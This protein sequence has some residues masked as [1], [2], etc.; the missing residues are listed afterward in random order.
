MGACIEKFSEVKS[1]PDKVYCD[2]NFI[3]GLQGY[4]YDR[5]NPKF[6][7]NYQFWDVLQKKSVSLFT[8]TLGVN[9]A[10]YI[11]FYLNGIYK[12]IKKH[13]G[14]ASEKR[15]PEKQ[16]RDFRKSNVK[17]YEQFYKSNLFRVKSLLQ[18]LYNC[19]FIILP[20]PP[21]S[22]TEFL[23]SYNGDA[24]SKYASYLIE[25]YSEIDVMDAFHI[26]MASYVSIKTIV[27]SDRGFWS[28]NKITVYSPDYIFH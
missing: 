17:L 26:A 18:F 27:T 3:F 14:T 19:G 4:I 21:S 20:I 12:D 7:M 25:N 10:I 16:I 5:K 11:S 13:L 23:L 22:A 28:V 6:E 2:T 8:S 1:F 9:E 24:V 15:L